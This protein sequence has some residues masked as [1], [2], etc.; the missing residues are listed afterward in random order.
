MPAILD[1]EHRVARDEIDELGH[2]NNVVYLEWMQAAALAHSA[3]QGWPPARYH[4]LG[5]GWVVRAHQITYYQPALQDDLI[6][7]R[8]WVATM[9]RVTSLRRFRILRRADEAL[10]ADAQTDWA[11]VDYQTGQP[12]RLPR[13]IAEAFVVVGHDL[14]PTSA[15]GP[16]VAN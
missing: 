11:F 3:A 5:C 16:S 13:E 14:P 4:Q 8:T 12:K 7:V 10:L 1:Y 15:N 2:A 6:L 9:K